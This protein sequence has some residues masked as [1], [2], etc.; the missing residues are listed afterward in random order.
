MELLLLS[1]DETFL[2]Y[3]LVMDLGKLWPRR[4]CPW[5]KYHVKR[6]QSSIL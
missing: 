3:K 5:S 1:S 2:A 4:V 6:L